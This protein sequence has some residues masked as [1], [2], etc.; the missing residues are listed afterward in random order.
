[1]NTETYQAEVAKSK[2]LTKF[3][4]SLIRAHYEPDMMDTPDSK[5]KKDAFLETSR[6]VAAYFEQIGESQLSSYVKVLIGD[7]KNVWVPM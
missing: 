2:Q 3:A 4:I 7:D 1:M 5:E 6:E